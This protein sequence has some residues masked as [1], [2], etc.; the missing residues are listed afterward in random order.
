MTKCKGLKDDGGACSKHIMYNSEYCKEH[1][2]QDPSIVICLS[3]DKRG[4]RCSRRA[5]EGMLFCKMHLEQVAELENLDCPRGCGKMEFK[6]GYIR[7][8][9]DGFYR[10]R[11]CEGRLLDAKRMD[12]IMKY[13]DD[14]SRFLESGEECDIRCPTCNSGMVDVRVKCNVPDDR[15]GGTHLGGGGGIGGLVLGI[16]I[17]GLVESA[18]QNN[19]ENKRRS[20]GSVFDGEFTYMSVDG[21][22]DCGSFWF[23][24]GEMQNIQSSIDLRSTT[25]EEWAEVEEM[26]E[27]R[28]QERLERRMSETGGNICSHVGEDGAPCLTQR[29]HN[30]EYCWKHKRPK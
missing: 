28:N 6:S 27:E 23:D 20:S 18:K 4:R 17:A 8:K 9:M 7:G 25:T 19:R 30:Q 2:H 11:E 26:L 13:S 21:C 15:G 24:G 10:C 14:L 5:M 29:M 16:A 3:E 1:Q 22:R 12:R